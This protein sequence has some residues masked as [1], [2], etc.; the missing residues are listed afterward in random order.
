ML[1]LT[2]ACP[3]MLLVASAGV[4][5]VRNCVGSQQTLRK[6]SVATTSAVASAT[7]AVT[8][9]EKAILL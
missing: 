1:N 7:V 2:S 3:F 5:E 4:A 8:I 9:A 6:K